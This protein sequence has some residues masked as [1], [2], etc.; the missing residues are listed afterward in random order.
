MRI[1][2]TVILAITLTACKNKVSDYEIRDNLPVA[3]KAVASQAAQTKNAHLMTAKGRNTCHLLKEGG[4]Q[5][6]CD[7]KLKQCKTKE[8]QDAFLDTCM[9]KELGDVN[10]KTLQKAY[11]QER[12]ESWKE[13]SGGIFGF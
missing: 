11:R 6:T 13:E 4:L 10:F 5:I 3:K 2:L 7:E 8:H 12:G 1:I 9:R